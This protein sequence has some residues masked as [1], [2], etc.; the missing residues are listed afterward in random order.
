MWENIAQDVIAYIDRI[1]GVT[2]KCEKCGKQTD[3]TVVN[4]EGWFVCSSCSE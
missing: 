1:N 2:W 3:R 4:Q